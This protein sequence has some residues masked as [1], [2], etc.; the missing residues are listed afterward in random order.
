MR[1]TRYRVKHRKDGF[2]DYEEISMFWYMA[3]YTISNVYLAGAFDILSLNRYQMQFYACK[4]FEK[5]N[6]TRIIN[7]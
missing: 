6:S 4:R 5:K 3:Q 1:I 7:S 2:I